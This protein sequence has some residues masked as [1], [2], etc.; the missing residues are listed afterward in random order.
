MANFPTSAPSFTNKSAGQTIGSAHMNAVQDEI[1][2]IGGGY[3]LG[4]APLNS[5]NSTLAHV[6][7]GAST[8]SALS[9]TNSTITNLQAGTVNVTSFNATGSTITNLAIGTIAIGTIDVGSAALTVTNGVVSTVAVAGGGASLP[10]TVVGYLSVSI[11][12]TTRKIP[13]YA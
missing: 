5:S 12:G 10:A 7:A 13:Y 3:V 4:T 8:I 2:A 9:V 6:S 11:N 1:V